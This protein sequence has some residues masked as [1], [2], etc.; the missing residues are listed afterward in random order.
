MQFQDE[1]GQQVLDRMTFKHN[2]MHRVI[3]DNDIL[4]KEAQCNDCILRLRRDI[5]LQ[6]KTIQMMMSPSRSRAHH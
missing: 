3:G 6:M 1:E 5:N 2:S 4:N